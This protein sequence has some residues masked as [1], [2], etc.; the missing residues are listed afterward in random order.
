MPFEVKED[1]L[2]ED[3]LERS[4]QANILERQKPA[5]PIDY[6]SLTSHWNKKSVNK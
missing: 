5:F 6:L 2:I 4:F 3:I 1:Y